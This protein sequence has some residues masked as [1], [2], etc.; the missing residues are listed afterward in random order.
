MTSPEE[1]AGMNISRARKLAGNVSVDP[2]CLEGEPLYFYSQGFREAYE[3]RSREVEKLL[4]YLQHDPDCILVHCDAG[5]P[6]E[7]GGYRQRFKGKW[8]QSR[9]VDETPKCNCGLDEALDQ[10]KASGGNK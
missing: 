3:Q 7:D 9:P 4:E 2:L 8:Y 6:T 10:F 5:E 1:E